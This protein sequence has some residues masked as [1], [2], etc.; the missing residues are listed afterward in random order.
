MDNDR[1][2][3][4]LIE[5]QEE[6]FRRLCGVGTAPLTVSFEGYH[7]HAILAEDRVFFFP[8]DASRVAGLR[9]EAVI[10]QALA[11]RGVPA[12]LLQGHWHDSSVSPYPFIA[13]S[14]LPG[15]T[16]GS[17]EATGTLAQVTSV[18][19][20]LG[21]AIASWHQLDLRTL[22]RSVRR[23]SEHVTDFGRTVERTFLQE[24][25]RVAAQQL[26]FPARQAMLWLRALE[27]VAVMDPVFV[28]GDIHAGQ[29][30]VDDALAVQGILDWETAG[31]GHPLK[32]FDFGEWGVGLFEWELHFD[33]LRQ[34]MWET[35]NQARGGRLPSW[36][37]IH[38]FF[39]LVTIGALGQGD[40]LTAWQQ[41]RLSNTLALL[42][43]LEI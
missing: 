20:G 36:R 4:I 7:R 17:Q 2:H 21:Q 35:Y 31:V 32:D 37:A 40:D 10:L 33:V 38:L 39:C 22:P 12:P 43:R 9:R 25:S 6:C 16:W 41:A 3:A 5:P 11:G 28:H 29:I 34:A 27:P 1:I 15:H 42:R 26:G 30:L 23:T 18:L 19:A 13:V 24:V 8:R 14:R